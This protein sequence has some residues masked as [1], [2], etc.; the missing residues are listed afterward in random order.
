LHR[1]DVAAVSRRVFGALLDGPFLCRAAGAWL[2]LLTAIGWVTLTLE[3]SVADGTVAQA[4]YL[5]IQIVAY[6]VE[7]VA[8]AACAVNVHRFLLLAE[9]PAPLRVAGTEWRYVRRGVWV[10]LPIFLLIVAV[11]VVIV[12]FPSPII[13]DMLG[14]WTSAAAE[15]WWSY[16]H[17]L[18]WLGAEVAAGIVVLPLFMSLPAVA[19]GRADFSLSDGIG[20]IRGNSLRLFAAF[21]IAVIVPTSVV[22]LA[23]SGTENLLSDFAAEPTFLFK[24]FAIAVEAGREVLGTV[25]WAAMLSCAYDGLVAHDREL[26][27]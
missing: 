6:I 10:S 25:I 13:S 17:A 18:A 1:L 20:V 15:P 2:V 16:A 23:A 27:T 7:P 21:M 9:H 22:G 11:A 8:L 14:R 4:V 12:V 3:R 19:I 24:A 5:I 26:T